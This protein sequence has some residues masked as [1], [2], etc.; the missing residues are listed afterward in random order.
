MH[1][2]AIFRIKVALPTG[3][4]SYS[5]IFH[6]SQEAFNQTEADFPFACSITV[7]FIKRAAT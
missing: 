3:K 4:F 2:M 7:I 5:G 1:V 6:D